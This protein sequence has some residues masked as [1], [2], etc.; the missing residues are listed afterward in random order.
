MTSRRLL[1]SRLQTNG[2]VDD[3][4]VKHGV[5]VSEVRELFGN[6]QHTRANRRRPDRVEVLGRTNGGR[7]LVV[8]LDPANDET[9]WQ[10]VTAYDAPPHLIVLIP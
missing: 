7:A 9:V 3:K 8:A 10:I 4:L 1:V 2:A 6:P 5:L